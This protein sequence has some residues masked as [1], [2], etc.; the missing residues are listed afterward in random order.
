MAEEAHKVQGMD[1]T[2]A[3]CGPPIK[4]SIVSQLELS[5]AVIASLIN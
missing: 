4:A 1:C 2:L 3:W 5:I